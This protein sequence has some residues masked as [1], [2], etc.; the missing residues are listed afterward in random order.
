VCQQ[1]GHSHHAK[2][3]HLDD[4]GVLHVV[5]PAVLGFC[6]SDEAACSHGRQ[7]AH[8]HLCVGVHCAF[9]VMLLAWLHSWAYSVAAG[10]GL[11]AGS[12]V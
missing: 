7:L 6:A 3:A 11:A 5:A 8:T 1:R 9:G 4:P 12:Q 10:H 2:A